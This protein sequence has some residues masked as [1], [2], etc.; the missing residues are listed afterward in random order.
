MEAKEKDFCGQNLG[1]YPIFLFLSFSYPCKQSILIWV[2]V[3]D[4]RARR[5]KIESREPHG[6]FKRRIF[7]LLFV[8]IP[9]LSCWTSCLQVKAKLQLTHSHLFAPSEEE[10]EEEGREFMNFSLFLYS[11]FRGYD[12]PSPSIRKNCGPYCDLHISWISLP[13][14]FAHSNYQSFQSCI[15]EFV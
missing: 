6:R 3:K 4:F 8:K 1:I 12:Q 14:S 13:T 2:T 10:E 5:K 9:I 11:L 7:L 15:L